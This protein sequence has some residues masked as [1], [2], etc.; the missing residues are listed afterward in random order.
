MEKELSKL[1]VS[2]LSLPFKISAL[3]LLAEFTNQTSLKH[4]SFY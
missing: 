1:N 2:N 3:K 4:T